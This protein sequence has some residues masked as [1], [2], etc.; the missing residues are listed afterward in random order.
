MT[1]DPPLLDWRDGKHWAKA[2][3]PCQHCHL[4]TFLRDDKKLPAHKVC[5]EQAVAAEEARTLNR[6]QN[7]F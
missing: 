5:A 2:E 1:G 3:A 7:G 6:Y 4:P